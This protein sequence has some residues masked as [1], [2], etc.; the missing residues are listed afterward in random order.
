MQ[1]NHSSDRFTPI[2]RLQ[3]T[4]HNRQDHFP[5]SKPIEFGRI[6]RC[7]LTSE[8]SACIYRREIFENK[9]L[10]AEIASYSISPIN[11]NSF[12]LTVEGRRTAILRARGSSSEFCEKPY[13]DQSAGHSRPTMTLC[14]KKS[15]QPIEQANRIEGEVVSQ[16]GLQE[17]ADR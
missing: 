6:S 16:N 5:G 9:G 12:V 8:F 13:V 1:K 14:Y 4:I 17:C 10:G 11:Q 7:R 2:T 3:S 15:D